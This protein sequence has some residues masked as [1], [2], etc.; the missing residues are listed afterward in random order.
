MSFISKLIIDTHFVRRGRYG[1]LAE[2]VANFPRLIGIGLAE[3]TG[4]IIK[5]CNELNK[6]RIILYAVFIMIIANN[7]E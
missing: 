3:N 5:R 4:L 2:A 6:C 1:R 7:K